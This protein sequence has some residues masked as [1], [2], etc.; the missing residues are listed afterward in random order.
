MPAADTSIND[1]GPKKRDTHAVNRRWRT[2]IE[3]ELLILD[4]F[5]GL[6]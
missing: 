5:R 3:N 6:L 1:I 4:Q 2:W